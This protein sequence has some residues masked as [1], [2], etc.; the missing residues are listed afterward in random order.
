LACDFVGALFIFF[1]YAKDKNEW[2]EDEGSMKP[3][4][5]RY[6]LFIKHPC[7]LKV[8]IIL[9]A[10]GFFLMVAGKWF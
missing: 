10:F 5:K 7:F 4:E 2:V 6:A 9:M 3:G 8:G 1:A